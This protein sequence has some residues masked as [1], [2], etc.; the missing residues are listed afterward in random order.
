[1]DIQGWYD[2]LPQN[3][4]KDEMKAVLAKKDDSNHNDVVKEFGVACCKFNFLFN[5]STIPQNNQ[6]Y[7]ISQILPHIKI[8]S[9]QTRSKVSF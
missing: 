9:R 2:A 4:V 7:Q 3:N 8:L 1:M 6:S 5:N